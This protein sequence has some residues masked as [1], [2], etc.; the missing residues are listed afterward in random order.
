MTQLLR[1][2]FRP[3][4]LL[5]DRDHIPR[6]SKTPSSPAR[7]GPC[8]CGYERWVAASRDNDRRR[9]DLGRQAGDRRLRRTAIVVLYVAPTTPAAALPL[10]VEKW[11][12]RRG[13]LRGLTGAGTNPSTPSL[14]HVR[15]SRP[16]RAADTMLE[17][18]SWHQNARGQVVGAPAP[19][20]F[21]NPSF[22]S[23]VHLQGARNV[24]CPR[25][26]RSHDARP[27]HWAGVSA[28]RGGRHR[29]SVHGTIL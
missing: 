23:A 16:F 21:L 5:R 18:P 17:T 29:A 1:G 15:P 4:P 10:G 2:T 13:K 14:E 9:V 6:R 8:T 7:S 11:P 20:P 27:M 3:R 25:D 12:V 28:W 26:H 24:F 19:G 22:I